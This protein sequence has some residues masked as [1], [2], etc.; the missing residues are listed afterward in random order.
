[1][2]HLLTLVILLSALPA[3]ALKKPTT[4]AELAE[5]AAISAAM[6]AEQTAY[7]A[8]LKSLKAAYDKVEGK[9]DTQPQIAAIKVHLAQVD[10]AHAVVMTDIIKRTTKLYDIHPGPTSG[11]IV[12]GEFTYNRPQWSPVF[13]PEAAR[14][15]VKLASGKEIIMWAHGSY[16][17]VTWADGTVELNEKAFLRSPAYLAAII[18]HESIHFAQST[19]VGRADRLSPARAEIEAHSQSSGDKTAALLGL[20]SEEQGLL[21]KAFQ[22]AIER[23]QKAPGQKMM[24][25]QFTPDGAVDAGE[26]AKEAGDDAFWARMREGGELAAAIGVA[27]EAAAEAGRRARDAEKKAEQ[28]K[29]AHEDERRRRAPEDA[30]NAWVGR[31]CAYMAYAETIPINTLDS[32]H[33]AAAMRYLQEVLRENDRLFAEKQR[34]DAVI[35]EYLLSHS[36][37]MKRSDIEAGRTRKNEGSCQRLILDMIYDAPDPIDSRWLVAQLDAKRDYKRGGGVLGAIIRG[38]ADGL[39]RGTGALVHGIQAPFVSDGSDS[40]GSGE[41]NGRDSGSGE[42]DSTGGDGRSSRMP[43]GDGEAMRQLR[44][45]ASGGRF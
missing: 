33:S 25:R 29:Q 17:G 24:S 45:I 19:T 9:I 8:M 26:A 41:S 38:I 6:A 10:A 20:T 3:S 32:S 14:R 39:R 4:K 12:G 42:S 40:G 34:S 44:G 22:A 13:A 16:A 15:T 1:M 36:V 37:V 11:Y 23:F 18:L 27:N 28:D 30:L 31:A 35:K 2:R 5:L 7:T 43:N 21:K